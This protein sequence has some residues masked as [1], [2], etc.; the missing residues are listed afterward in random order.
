MSAPLE[1]MMVIGEG[2]FRHVGRGGTRTPP[3]HHDDLNSPLR[4]GGQGLNILLRNFPSTVDERA[5]K[6]QGNEANRH[7]QRRF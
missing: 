3:R 2:N 4:R 5:V 7:M 1:V 6:V